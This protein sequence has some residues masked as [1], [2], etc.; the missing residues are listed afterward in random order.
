M[1]P[2]SSQPA[3]LFA[4]AK[5]HKFTDI[6]QIN[7]NNL[8]LCPIIDQTGTHLYHCSKII[9]QY[10]QP[11]AINEYTISDYL[12]FPDVFQENPLDSN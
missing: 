5:A 9:I 10:L 6:K 2:A 8:K 4:T 3:R 7:I 11:L 12:P 1:K